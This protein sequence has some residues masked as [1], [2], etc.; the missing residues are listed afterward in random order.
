M[1]DIT[2]EALINT[3]AHQNKMNA[4]A[5]VALTKRIE[6]GEL[7]EKELKLLEFPPT[8]AMLKI[9]MEENNRNRAT[10]GDKLTL[11]EA[12]DMMGMAYSGAYSAIRKFGIRR[13]HINGR[14]FVPE[15]EIRQLIAD[16]KLSE[17]MAEIPTA[18]GQTEASP[19]EQAERASELRTQGRKG[20]K[21]VRINMAFTPENHEFIK[22]MAR[23][24]GRTMT[25]FTNLV[26]SAYRKEH[27]ELMAAA[28]TFIEVINS[29]A[30]S[31]L[32][33]DE[34]DELEQELPEE[35]PATVYEQTTLSNDFGS[36]CMAEPPTIKQKKFIWCIEHTLPI[37]FCGGTRRDA[38]QWIRN[39]KAEF[40]AAL[41]ESKERG[42]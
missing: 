20:C 36:G 1:K 9:L 2:I 34:V 11:Q 25:E 3:L 17:D 23:A 42:V 28:G 41:D 10:R 22:V 21:A 32:P 37:R 8:E 14:T 7:R 12:A 29:G 27:P 4:A 30:F 13:L 31:A 35:N 6:I 5:K 18:T 38:R 40:E 26:I 39:H 19:E 16:K 33:A 24:S 15:A